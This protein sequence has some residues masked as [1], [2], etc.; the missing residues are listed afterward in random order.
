MSPTQRRG[1]RDRPAARRHRAGRA[2]STVAERTLDNGLRV[3]AVR[4]P[5][6]PLV[7]MRLR[8]PFLSAQAPRIPPGRR[9]WP[10]R[11]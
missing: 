4:K 9:C 10:T 11:S 6:V 7:E 3:V 8:V 1:A 2:S 5:G